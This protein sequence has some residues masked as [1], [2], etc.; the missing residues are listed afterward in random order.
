[1]ILTGAEILEQQK[2]GRLRIDPFHPDQI[3]PN[4]YDFRLGDALEVY[5]REELDSR[6]DNPRKSIRIPDEGIML[7]TDRVYLAQTQEEIGSDYFVPMIHA[8]SSIARLG[9]FIHVTCDVIEIGSY[10]RSILQ[11]HAVQPVR[12]F[13]GMRIGQVTFWS[14]TGKIG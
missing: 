8:R 3:S 6:A 4:S 2:A 12:I 11:L 14:V 10:D 13:K 1:M 7:R 9:L 5:E